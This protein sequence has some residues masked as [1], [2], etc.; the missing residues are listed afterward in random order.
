LVKS[1]LPSFLKRLMSVILTLKGVTF[2]NPNLPVIP[3]LY[4][5]G[6]VA[7]FRPATD[8]A[9]M[10]DISGNETGLTLVGSANYNEFGV[11]TEPDNGFILDRI[12]TPSFSYA[13]AY[14]V[15]YEIASPSG[16]VQVVGSRS[17]QASPA[18][19][20]SIQIGLFADDDST[21]TRLQ[22]P[23]TLSRVSGT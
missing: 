3:R 11:Q 16:T 12:E 8:A 4:S 17:N 19:G 23:L 14:R 18:V 2:N 7:A 10:V 15:E 20:R 9:S 1:F 5:D 22:H 6:L 13:A 21:G